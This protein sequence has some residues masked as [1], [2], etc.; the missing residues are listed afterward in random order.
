M[1]SNPRYF[2]LCRAGRGG[3]AGLFR[4]IENDDYRFEYWNRK[5]GWRPDPSLASY[6]LRGEPGAEEI[7]SKRAAALIRRRGGRLD[8]LDRTATGKSARRHRSGLRR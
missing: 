1:P 3:P 6:L 8:A 4:L 7:P 2:L 5:T